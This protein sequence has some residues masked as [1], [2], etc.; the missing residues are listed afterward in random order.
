MSRNDKKNPS[1]ATPQTDAEAGEEGDDI[2]KAKRALKVMFNRGLIDKETYQDRLS[3]LT[4][5][6]QS[7]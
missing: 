5:G 1:A 2:E 7:D 4:S 3:N 6:D